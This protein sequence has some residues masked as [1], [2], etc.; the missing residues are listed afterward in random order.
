[1]HSTPL[2]NILSIFLEASKV[3]LYVVFLYFLLLALAIDIFALQ[4]MSGKLIRQ[5]VRWH[6]SPQSATPQ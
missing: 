1:M 2:R 4:Y 5:K 3:I 6:V